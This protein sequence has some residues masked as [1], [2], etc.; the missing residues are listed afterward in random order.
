MDATALGDVKALSPG[1]A[2]L[3]SSITAIGEFVEKRADSVHEEYHIVA[4]KL[5]A[6]LGTHADAT[7]PSRQ[8]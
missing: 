2:Y 5:D 3:E 1:Q 4:K 6:K 7:G 8:K